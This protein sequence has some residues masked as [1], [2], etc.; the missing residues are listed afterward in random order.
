M[1]LTRH[2]T[3]SEFEFSAT[4]TRKDIPN[5]CPPELI[6]NMINVANH[7]EIVRAYFGAPIR[8]LSGYRSQALNK[9]VGGSK[10]S[11]HRTGSAA[12]FIVVGVSVAAVAKYIAENM[13]GVDQII[14]EFPET[15]GWIHIGF[16]NGVPREQVLTASKVDGNTYRGILES[17]IAA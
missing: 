1:N 9:A 2:F 4:G 11:A 8:V 13:K 3:K 12:D 15:G 7:L 14:L 16:T 10:T 6:S 17:R 5:I